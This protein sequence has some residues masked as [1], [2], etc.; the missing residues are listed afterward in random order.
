[1]LTAIWRLS[2][3]AEETVLA[4]GQPGSKVIMMIMPKGKVIMRLP[5]AGA[6]VIKVIT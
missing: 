5:S 2:A 3:T 1:M 6:K 4:R